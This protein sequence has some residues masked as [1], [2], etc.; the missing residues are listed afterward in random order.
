MYRPPLPGQAAGV[1]MGGGRYSHDEIH[2]GDLA[3]LGHG[4][5]HYHRE[6]YGG[7]SGAVR[8]GAWMEI[9]RSGDKRALRNRIEYG[10]HRESGQHHQPDAA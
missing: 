1:S 7:A 10:T 2:S 4:R 6:C 3:G 5:G 8:F 9:E